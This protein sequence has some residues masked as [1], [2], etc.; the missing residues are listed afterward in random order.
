MADGY[1]IAFDFGLRHIGVAAGQTV[2]GN[3]T[4]VTT[5]RAEQGKPDWKSVGEL[6]EAWAPLRLLVGLPL[7]MDGTESDMSARARAFAS[8]LQRRTGIQVI[9]V[10]E[11]LTSREALHQQRSPRSNRAQRPPQGTHEQAAVLI[12]ESWL[13]GQTRGA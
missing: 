12:A 10:D 5:L 9:L 2:T 11:R 8:K 13:S 4:G 1:V 7:N 3:A 6:I